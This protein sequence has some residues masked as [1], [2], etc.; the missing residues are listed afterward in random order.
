[1]TPPIDLRLR[2]LARDTAA[3]ASRLAVID[4]QLPPAPPRSRENVALVKPLFA[5]ATDLRERAESISRDLFGGIQLLEKGP[6]GKLQSDVA[7]VLVPAWNAARTVAQ[8]TGLGRTAH[9][10]TLT[11]SNRGSLIGTKRWEKSRANRDLPNTRVVGALPATGSH[12]VAGRLSSVPA[13]L[14]GLTDR[15]GTR[16]TVFTGVLTDV[17]GYRGLKGR[18]PRGWPKGSTW[19]I[20]PGAGG[21]SGFAANVGK[22][23]PGKANG[24]GSTSLSLHEYGHTVDHAL[25]ATDSLRLTA[26]RTWRDGPWRELR[27]DS[28]AKEYYRLHAEEWFAESFARYFKSDA[29]RAALARWYPVTYEWIDENIGSDSARRLRRL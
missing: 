23:A 29:D 1:M 22:D 16:A 18:R 27:A 10:E 6:K 5:A 13:K 20:V 11:A 17:P 19:D 9:V 12:V 7:A 8:T 2:A 14:I 21:Q 4:A 28:N 25:G 26:E 24:H 15:L 3:F